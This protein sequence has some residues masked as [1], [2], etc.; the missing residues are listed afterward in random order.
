MDISGIDILP[1][2]AVAAILAISPGPDLLLVINSALHRRATAGILAAL[3]VSLGVLLW[4][5]LAGFGLMT[6]LLSNEFVFTGLTLS[7][8]IGLLI[9]G[10]TEIRNAV[11]TVGAPATNPAGKPVSCMSCF[12]KGLLVNLSN[13]KVGVFYVVVLP[14]FV[15]KEQLGMGSALLLGGIHVTLGLV[16]YTL[17]AVFV[18]ALQDRLISRRVV[19]WMQTGTGAMFLILA[20]IVIVQCMDRIS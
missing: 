19:G 2:T 9:I 3:G 17:C 10:L 15:T 8:A 20:L 7:G 1:F 16:W 14:Q 18:D 12:G 13:P 5:C 4:S 11:M 6:V